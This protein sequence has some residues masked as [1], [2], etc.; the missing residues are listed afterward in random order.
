MLLVAR[1]AGGVTMDTA[2]TMPRVPSAPMNSCLRS[3]PARRQMQYNDLEDM[4][5]CCPCGVSKVDPKWCRLG[6]R[7]QVR[8]H[9]REG[10]RIAEGGDLLHLSKRFHLFDSFKCM[11]NSCKRKAI[12]RNGPSLCSQVERHDMVMGSNVI[13]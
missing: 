3:Y 6:V 8:V 12:Q 5:R 7:L 13:T 9:S 11:L 10:N 4:Y 2:V 1:G